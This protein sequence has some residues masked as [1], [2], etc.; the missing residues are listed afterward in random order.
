M[1][2]GIILKI[3]VGVE[4][5][6]GGKD[7]RANHLCVQVLAKQKMEERVKWPCPFIYKV[8]CT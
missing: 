4:K 2:G 7:V 5:T 1:G 6:S 8:H 3:I